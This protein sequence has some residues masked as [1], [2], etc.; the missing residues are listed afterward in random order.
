MILT[1]QSLVNLQQNIFSHFSNDF[2]RLRSSSGFEGR[3]SRHDCEVDEFGNL[4]FWNATLS[5]CIPCTRCSKNKGKNGKYLNLRRCGHDRDTVCGTFEEFHNEIIKLHR[6]K[7]LQKGPKLGEIS[8]TLLEP[9]DLI[10]RILHKNNSI[11]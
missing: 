8:R 9:V 11:M 3:K 7:Q 4:E 5:S 1:D 6:K 2:S 10:G